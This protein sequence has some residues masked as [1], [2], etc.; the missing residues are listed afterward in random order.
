MVDFFP[1]FMTWQLHRL[2]GETSDVFLEYIQR[3]LPEGVSMS[4]EHTALE[5]IP[6]YLEIPPQAKAFLAEQKTISSSRE[7]AT[8]SLP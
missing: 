4:V 8:S 3:N 6:E 5:E 2:T 1:Y 7:T